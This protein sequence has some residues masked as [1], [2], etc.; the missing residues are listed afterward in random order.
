MRNKI[1]FICM[2]FV[3]LLALSCKHENILLNQPR[4]ESRTLKV[5]LTNNFEYSLFAEALKLTGYLDTLDSRETQFTVL[6]IKNS[7]WNEEGVFNKRDLEKMDQN[8]LK[9]VIG[10]HILPI[11]LRSQ[12]IPIN[13][14]NLRYPTLSGKELFVHRTSIDITQNPDEMGSQM[15]S[16]SGSFISNRITLKS[17]FAPKEIQGDYPFFNGVLHSLTKLIK[18]YGDTTVQMYLAGN[19]DYSIFVAGL[20]HFGLWDRLDDTHL[21]TVFAPLNSAFKAYGITEEIIQGLD[22]KRF[23]GERLFGAYLM[24]G[25]RFFISDYCFYLQKDKEYWISTDLKG[26]NTYKQIIIG[27]RFNE[28][29]RVFSTAD[30]A[31]C[32]VAISKQPYPIGYKET[33]VTYDCSRFLG[34]IDSEKA[35]EISICVPYAEY[36][37]KNDYLFKNGNVHQLT[38]LLVYFEEAIRELN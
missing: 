26:D 13:Q 17:T 9:Q 38:G 10:Y 11:V 2:F 24:Y 6:A 4:E 12:D 21:V 8:W 22:P 31:T 33:D 34:G 18:F 29:G 5:F 36:K 28:N 20:K 1:N 32:W 3:F 35:L 16:F 15:I 7:V 14:Y 19:P 25:K 30:Y 27:G 23:I 37:F